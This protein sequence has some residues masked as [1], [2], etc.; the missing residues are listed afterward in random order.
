M[1]LASIAVMAVIALS[2]CSFSLSIPVASQP[3]PVTLSAPDYVTG[4]NSISGALAYEERQPP[5]VLFP[6]GPPVTLT[7]NPAATDPTWDEL[8]AFV[9]ADATD[10]NAY[11]P[12][13]YMCGGFAQD[14]HN[15]AEATGIR[16]GW[17]AID[18]YD[19]SVGHAA[20]AFNTTDR[21]LVVI[22]GTSSYDTGG[23]GLGGGGSEGFDKVAYVVIGEDYGVIALEVAASPLYNYYLSYL[24]K[25]Q[26]FEELKNDYEQQAAAYNQAA[27]SGSQSY[28][29]LK[30]WYQ[31]LKDMENELDALSGE[32][33][34]YYW[35]SLGTVSEVKVY[36]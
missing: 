25:M 26:A 36:W 12:D 33:G 13:Y 23:R 34:G 28:G 1:V 17:I 29:S 21:G 8:M 6:G 22:D 4:H 19:K 32:L 18:F 24:D 35:E 7:N 14:L 27:K 5:Y 9:R 3:P 31:R 11:L 10:R 15:N 30:D 2:G 20:T 16:A